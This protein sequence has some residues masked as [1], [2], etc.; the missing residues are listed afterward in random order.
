MSSCLDGGLS[1]VG[2]PCE[3][4]GHGLLP[5][6]P[7]SHGSLLVPR[8]MEGV[9]RCEVLGSGLAR[10][11]FLGGGGGG[12]E[13]AVG[14]CPSLRGPVCPLGWGELGVSSSQGGVWA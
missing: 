11:G 7:E 3:L 13:S 5:W 4:P 1:L 10:P 12:E 14:F 6:S 9:K 2:G 8:G